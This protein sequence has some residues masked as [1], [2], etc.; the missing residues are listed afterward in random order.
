MVRT[1]IRNKRDADIPEETIKLAISNVLRGNMSLRTVASAFNIKKS[2]LHDR[3]SKAKQKGN[4]SD[5]GNESD[6]DTGLSK[7]A[8]RQQSSQILYGLTYTATRKLAYDYALKLG[9]NYP[10]Q[11][12][13]NKMAGIEWIRSFMKRHPKLSLRK[14]ENTSVARASAFNKYNVNTFFDN[15]AE[16]QAKYNFTPNRIWNTDETGISTVMQAPKVIAETGKRVV[17]QCV[18]AERG[19]LVTFCGTISATGGTIPP[20]YIYPRI[21][22]KDHFLHGSI[23]GSVGYGTKSGW[24]TAEVFVKLLEHIQN[25]T[26]STPTSPILLLLDNHETH[27]SVDAINFARNN[28]IV[29]LSFPPH[30]THK[31]SRW[32]RRFVDHLSKRKPITIYEIAKLTNEPFLQSFTPKNITSA[33]L[34]TGLWPI[35]R[36]IFSEEDFF[37]A[38]A[39]DQVDPQ[40]DIPQ[41]TDKS[42]T[43]GNIS[44]SQSTNIIDTIIRPSDDSI[45]NQ[46]STS[47]MSNTFFTSCETIKDTK[48]IVESL[49]SILNEIIDK[50]TMVHI[51]IISVHCLKP[52]DIRPFPQA[53]PRKTNRQS[54]KGK[55]RVYTSTPEK[56]RV[57]ELENIRKLQLENSGTKKKLTIDRN[58]TAAKKLQAESASVKSQIR[59]KNVTRRKRKRFNDSSSSDSDMELYKDTRSKFMAYSS[60]SDIK[61]ESDN[62]TLIK[63]LGGKA[64][65]ENLTPELTECGLKQDIMNCLQRVNFSFKASYQTICQLA[66]IAYNCKKRFIEKNYGICLL[67]Y[68][69]GVLLLH[70]NCVERGVWNRNRKEVLDEKLQLLFQTK[71]IVQ[72]RNIFP[73]KKLNRGK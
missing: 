36:L 33:F 56:N 15:Y 8:T 30:C 23:P 18:S 57:E 68:T 55:S 2:T 70:S 24:M 66:A 12:N 4:V 54:R 53:N 37:G 3:L 59:M 49:E 16:V 26:K 73:M 47:T 38:Y 17:D 27:V 69:L 44:K 20:M 48:T 14:P 34:S 50:A 1:Y 25:H 61:M 10:S 21:R 45:F 62:D 72:S 28:G 13:L 32:I 22:I 42:L 35:N 5:S 9:K 7:Y 46:P 39:T 43:E 52:A 40:L 6:E 63:L 41:C 67:D 29:L 65:E 60:D 19:T 11:W 31:C 64:G 58:E 71:T 51:N